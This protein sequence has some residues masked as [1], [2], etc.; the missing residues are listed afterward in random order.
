MA[1]AHQQKLQKAREQLVIQHR[2]I[3]EA[4]AGSSKRGNTEQ[5]RELMVQIQAT[6]DAVD[7]AMK[8]EER[9]SPGAEN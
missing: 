1:C 3:A 2:A 7:K 5:C 8:D 4:L 6:I 9:L